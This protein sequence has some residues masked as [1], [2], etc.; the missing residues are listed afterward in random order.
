MT[1]SIVTA[2]LIAQ[3]DRTAV[4][5]EGAVRSVR[6]DEADAGNDFLS[7]LLALPAM[8][9]SATTPASDVADSRKSAAEGTARAESGTPAEAARPSAAIAML[10]L[11]QQ[12]LQ[13]PDRPLPAGD[14]GGEGQ[15]LA[16][17]RPAAGENLAAV[18]PA[19]SGPGAAEPVRP[20]TDGRTLPAAAADAEPR[21]AILAVP[22][23]A[24]L[25]LEQTAAEGADP[26]APALPAHTAAT[27]A[28]AGTVPHAAAYSLQA[29][30]RD[31]SWA[32]EFGQ[33]LLWFANN[34]QQGAKITVHPPQLGVIE[35]SLH[36]DRD[37]ATAHFASANA[38]VRGAIEA[39]MPRLREMFAGAGIEL[40]QLSVGSQSSGEQ[41]QGQRDSSP[42][43][44]RPP[45]AAILGSDPPA[46]VFVSSAATRHGQAMIDVFA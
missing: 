25:P 26:P 46:G 15:R 19:R 30:L 21:A 45:D 28:G 8:T 27:P 44:H 34:E 32:S 43:T 2:A 3:P 24:T 23:P 13:T 40:G 1:I 37:G 20:A 4:G 17:P 12:P 6:A 33:K 18:L 14:G 29:P 41:S 10:V 38:E 39:A 31:P 11:G 16:T 22:G 7:I 9:G 42:A 36:L 35:I 5:D